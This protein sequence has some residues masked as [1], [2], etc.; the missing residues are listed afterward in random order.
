MS[1]VPIS[2]YEICSSSQYAQKAPQ[3][4]FASVNTRISYA[5]CALLKD[6][7]RKKRYPYIILF[8]AIGAALLGH[9]IYL[10]D[11]SKNENSVFFAA[12]AAVIP[13]GIG[14]A[15]AIKSYLC[16]GRMIIKLGSLEGHYESRLDFY[17]QE[18]TYRDS[19]SQKIYPDSALV[20]PYSCISTLL[21]TDDAAVLADEDE[22]GFYML[23]KDMPA[24]LTEKL[25]TLCTNAKIKD[26][27]IGSI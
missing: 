16:S 1:V 11:S 9:S 4:P 14:I 21:L 20:I 24:Q 13:F 17:E 12:L 15:F 19:F 3:P 22:L 10:S 7:F 6:T 2:K 8:F 5:E 25:C 26:K 18:F 23:Q 27:R